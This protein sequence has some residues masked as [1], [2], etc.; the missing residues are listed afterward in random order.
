MKHEIYNQIKSINR[1]LIQT[2]FSVRHNYPKFD[3]NSLVWEGFR[4]LAFV[5]KSSPYETVYQSCL[6]AN[7]YNFLLLDGAIIQLQYKFKRS[8]LISH[9]LR[10][11]PSPSSETY[12][13][14]PSDFEYNYY[15][16]TLFT[17]VR[18]VESVG[19][20]IR[21]DFDSDLSKYVEIHHPVSHAT[22]GNVIN[23]RIPV[24]KPV[25]PNTFMMFILRNFYFDKFVKEF[26]P[27]LLNCNINF[28]STISNFESQ[29]LHFNF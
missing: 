5:L 17:E 28:Q 18:S 13:S 11:Y 19:F 29:I 20:P 16:N 10:F 9:I 23:C 6:E 7:D 8:D 15:G 3:D 27:K 12:Q 22:L 2:G 24:S 26:D 21:F 14:S 4:N 25:S 1:Y